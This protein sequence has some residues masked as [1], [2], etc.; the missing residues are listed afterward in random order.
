MR[1]TA[2]RLYGYNL[3]LWL[4]NLRAS[5]LR[6]CSVCLGEIDVD[7]TRGQRR[8]LLAGE[9]FIRHSAGPNAIMIFYSCRLW[10]VLPW[11]IER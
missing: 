10:P 6:R 11:G 2:P 8:S 4:V 5:R 3:V 7:I 9:W 1:H